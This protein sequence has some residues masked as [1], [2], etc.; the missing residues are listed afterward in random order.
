MM[1]G[2]GNGMT[3]HR[4]RRVSVCIHGSDVPEPGLYVLADL[5]DS[6]PGWAAAYYPEP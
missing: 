2:R 6:S 3:P 5:G 4:Y 1:I